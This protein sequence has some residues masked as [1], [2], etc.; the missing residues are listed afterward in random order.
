MKDCH[1]SVCVCVCVCVCLSNP[2]RQAILKGG[3]GESYA[4]L[5]ISN[6]VTDYSN[7]YFQ[8]FFFVLWR[9]NPTRA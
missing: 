1:N 9:K 8:T 6:S 4:D 2:C 5:N 7:K 3:F